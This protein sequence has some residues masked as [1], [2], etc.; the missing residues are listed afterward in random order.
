M[1]R[2]FISFITAAAL[3]ITTLGS[4]PATAGEHET[5]RALAALLGVAVVGAILHDRHKDKK[6]RHGA[7]RR[8]HEPPRYQPPKRVD[9]KLLPQ[10]C[11]R[12]YE[13]YNG[14]VRMFGNRC[15]KNNYAFAHKLPRRCLYIFD[16]PKGDRRGYEARCLRRE[17]YRLAHG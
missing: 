8:V 2:K 7:P 15:L 14:K 11:F 4:T 5:A 10:Q 16:T 6:V 13:T 9:R 12:S 1:P 17:G 3:T